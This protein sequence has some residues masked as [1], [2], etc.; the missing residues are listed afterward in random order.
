MSD[1]IY[2]FYSLYFYLL[3][4]VFN[5]MTI[6]SGVSVGWV[7]ITCLVFG[8]LIRSLLA[9]PRA[10]QSHTFRSKDGRNDG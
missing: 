9:V 10:A 8:I 7:A 2:V 1:A 4:F 5:D 3:N 6:V